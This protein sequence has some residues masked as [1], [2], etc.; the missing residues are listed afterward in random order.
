MKFK[1][2]V[3]IVVAL[4]S[5]AT[6]ASYGCTGAVD[7]LQLG[8]DGS[9]AVKSNSLFGDND[10][11]VFCNTSVEYQGMSAEACRSW[12]SLLLSAQ[13][14]TASIWVQYVDQ[15]SC[16]TQPTWAAAS[17]PHAVLIQ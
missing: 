14:S 17:R 3:L 2:M 6:L 8:H 4:F 5:H 1:C 16:T 7:Q 12:L 15:H 11:R 13:V 10:G 9:I